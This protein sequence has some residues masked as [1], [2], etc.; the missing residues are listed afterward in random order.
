MTLFLIVDGCLGTY[1]YRVFSRLLTG[2][3]MALE[4]PVLADFN[5]H[6]AAVLEAGLQVNQGHPNVVLVLYAA[7]KPTI[8]T[9]GRPD[10]H[11]SPGAS[12]DI[13]TGMG[14]DKHGIPLPP[15]KTRISPSFL[16][17]DQEHP[18]RSHLIDFSVPIPSS[19]QITLCT[20]ESTMRNAPP[21]CIF[22]ILD[23]MVNPERRDICSHRLRSLAYDDPIVSARILSL[24]PPHSTPLVS[25]FWFSSHIWHTY[26]VFFFLS[27]L[28]VVLFSWG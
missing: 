10:F 26:D 17:V 20:D 8:L 4:V 14:Q 18:L 9:I 22:P 16:H 23:F 3:A 12:S 21:N 6:G 1:V 11:R 2:S 28:H 27:I 13:P 7:T 24:K 19:S 15:A 5:N 25:L